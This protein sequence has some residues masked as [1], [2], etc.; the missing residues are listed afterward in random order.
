MKRNIFII[1][2][3]LYI[4]FLYG[5]QYFS[6]NF[7]FEVTISFLP[8]FQLVNI[9]ILGFLLILF[10]K[11]KI[12]LFEKVANN[13]EVHMITS[14]LLVVFIFF[15]VFFN[16]KII[17]FYFIPN[18]QINSNLES[19]DIKV[20]FFNKNFTNN[21]YDEISKAFTNLNPDVIIVAESE[22]LL[23][24]KILKLKEYP[25]RDR[26]IGEKYFPISIYSKYKIENSVYNSNVDLLYNEINFNGKKINI[27][28]THPVAPINEE[29]LAYRNRQLKIICNF[30]NNIIS[31][32][33]ILL[34]DFNLS[35]WSPRYEEFVHCLKN[36]KNTAKGQGIK[37]TWTGNLLTKP[38]E[39]KTHIDHIFISD[40]LQLNMYQIYGNYHSD[41]NLIFVDLNVY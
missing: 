40:D 29:A 6:Y 19:T 8:Y 14:V 1:I 35:N 34:G 24:E 3:C 9:F 17:D 22:P 23:E 16:I 38:F 41:H 27:I 10:Y 30:S 28:S 26:S 18:H 36:M 33:K 21:N 37:F 4:S 31:K 32:S 25:F 7:F 20:S 11:S 13:Y 15:T 39:I 12:F 5:L 2:S